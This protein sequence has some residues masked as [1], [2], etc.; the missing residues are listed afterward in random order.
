M[1]HDRLAWK[2]EFRE[3]EIGF[4]APEMQIIFLCPHSYQLLRCI[5]LAEFYYYLFFK[6]TI[7][8]EHFF[9]KF[10]IFTVFDHFLDG[11]SHFLVKH[12]PENQE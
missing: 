12:T 11:L 1:I 10:F 6:Q 4:D 5:C 7:I 2:R 3:N 8:L 9:R